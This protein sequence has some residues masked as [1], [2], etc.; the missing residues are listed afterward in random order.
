MKERLQDTISKLDTS[1]LV[2]HAERIL[3]QPVTLSKQF[4]AGQYWICF[5]LVAAN[6]G[7]VIA[8]V[9]LPRHPDMPASLSDEDEQYSI[10]CE[11]ATM[12]YVRKKLPAVKLPQV[13]AYEAPGSLR[14]SSVG[15]AY[16]LLEGFYGNTLQDV[17]FD[18]CSLAISTQVHII[19]QWTSAQ[20]EIATL[21][22]ACIGSI[23]SI[24]ENGEPVLGRLAS[25]PI[26]GLNSSGPFSSTTEYFVTIADS[27][28]AKAR[29]LDSN[30][31][32]PSYWATMGTFVFQDI[33]HNTPLYH[34]TGE[35]SFPLNHMDLGTQNILIDEDYNFLAII[36][37]EFAQTAPWPVNYYP[38]PF[39]LTW[40]DAKTQT[41]LQDTA[42]LAHK[43]ISKQ[44]A[45]QKMYVQ[46]FKD[47]ETQLQEQGRKLVGSFA[48]VF[49]RP[50]SR[51]YACF[52]RLGRLPTADEDMVRTMV[53]LAFACG[54][55][56]TEAYLETIK[57]KAS[58]K[59][60]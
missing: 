24:S 15:A 27:A 26:E 36:D 46:K 53:Q 14:A 21:A 31:S 23:S 33:V 12:K 8:R 18:I 60:S 47:A 49:D 57:A 4:S 35:E 30:P 48:D 29:P 1:F 16:M 59:G 38:M 9:R 34:V 54:S 2:D 52:T 55:E 6:E 10:N 40:P 50:P 13:Y 58:A 42:H 39:S 32:D 20:A 7:L 19:T 28:A 25:A 17:T 41:I 37:W 44:D 22:F 43:N 5:E 11:V 51:I 56:E 3:G 45:A